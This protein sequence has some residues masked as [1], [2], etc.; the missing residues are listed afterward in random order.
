MFYLPVLRGVPDFLVWLNKKREKRDKKKIYKKIKRLPSRQPARKA[1]H[2][3]RIIS[4]IKGTPVM[5]N[6]FCEQPRPPGTHRG[7]FPTVVWFKKKEKL[8]KFA[9]TCSPFPWRAVSFPNLESSVLLQDRNMNNLQK[10]AM[11]CVLAF[12]RN[13][14]LKI[15]RN[16]RYSKWKCVKFSPT[17]LC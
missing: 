17:E 6:I 9:E 11:H 8:K 3:F 15:V 1:W 4:K 12:W 2:T 13:F 14:N 10:T 16:C 7:P 5:L